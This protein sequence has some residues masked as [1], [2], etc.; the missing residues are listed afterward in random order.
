MSKRKP[1]NS[2]H[3][4]RDRLRPLF[5]DKD[6]KLVL[7]FGSAAT[8]KAHGQSD[9]DLGFLFEGRVDILA[10]TNKVTR[11]LG[12]DNVDVVDLGRASPL[13]RF[14]AAKTGAIV[15][16]KEKGIF[17]AFCSLAFRIYVDTAKLRE[18]QKTA[19]RRFLESRQIS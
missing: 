19:L 10:L 2:I 12:M 14:S 17:N 18:A 9:I 15:H 7:L 13:L 11:L 1:P 4:I 3:D 8:G 5:E 6:L 16:E